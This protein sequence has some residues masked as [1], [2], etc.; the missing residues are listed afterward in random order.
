MQTQRRLPA[1]QRHVPSPLLLLVLKT[2]PKLLRH[3]MDTP[4]FVSAKALHRTPHPGFKLGA[5]KCDAMGRKFSA[6]SAKIPPHAHPLLLL[7]APYFADQ[8]GAVPF[9]KVR[10]SHPLRPCV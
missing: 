6:R 9:A 4:H 2:K 5:V 10:K 7:S 8:L 1:S 3:D